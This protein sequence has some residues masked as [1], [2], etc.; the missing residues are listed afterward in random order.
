[1]FGY[2]AFPK[3]D[4]STSIDTRNQDV[5]PVTRSDKSIPSVADPS[6]YEYKNR[7]GDIG[8]MSNL[9]DKRMLNKP[10]A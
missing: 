8:K 10:R 3:N 4:T 1:M 5:Q 6:M 7:A 9:Q 2:A